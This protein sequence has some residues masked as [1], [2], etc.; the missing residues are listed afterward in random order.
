MASQ[1][2]LN[3]LDRS[4][5]VDA[6]LELMDNTYVFEYINWVPKWRVD[7]LMDNRLPRFKRDGQDIRSNHLDEFDELIWSGIGDMVKVANH[8]REKLASLR[9][10]YQHGYGMTQDAK[11][12]IALEPV[13]QTEVNELLRAQ[14]LLS[15]G[16]SSFVEIYRLLGGMAFGR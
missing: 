2:L 8:K 7:S 14:L 5:S 12:R 6:Y 15:E 10:R 4:K 13:I 3:K 1:L 11:V 9:M 16:A